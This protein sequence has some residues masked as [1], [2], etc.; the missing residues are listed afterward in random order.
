MNNVY[1]EYWFKKDITLMNRILEC[2]L[3]A[4]GITFLIYSLFVPILVPVMFAMFF[5]AYFYHRSLKLEYEYTLIDDDFKIDKIIA[6]MKRKKLAYYDLH[7]LVE[8]MHDDEA[9]VQKY[10]K[11]KHRTKRYISKWHDDPV[12]ILVLRQGGLYTCVYIQADE[13]FIKALKIKH[14]LAFHIA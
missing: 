4:S 7:D 12:Y 3:I 2:L 14:A 6:K 8:V 13:P 1:Y 10:G 11:I 5:I 9:F